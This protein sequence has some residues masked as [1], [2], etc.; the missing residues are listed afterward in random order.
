MGGKTMS[1]RLSGHLSKRSMSQQ[2]N[3]VKAAARYLMKVKRPC[4]ASEVFQHMTTK[5]GKLYRK[6]RG[7]STYSK[8]RS[9]MLRH[10]V[11]TNHNTTPKTFTCNM[12]QYNSYFDD[13]PSFDWTNTEMVNERRALISSLGCYRDE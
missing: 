4:S 13:D 1:K 3:T 6:C 5:S 10:P 12:T 8:L 9:K 11:F 7:S 2:N